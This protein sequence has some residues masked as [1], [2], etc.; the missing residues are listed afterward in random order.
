LRTPPGQHSEKLTGIGTTGA[1]G[2]V[3]GVSDGRAIL[4]ELQRAG[5]ADRDLAYD[6]VMA[7]LATGALPISVLRPSRG[8]ALV[9]SWFHRDQINKLARIAREPYLLEEAP[10]P[11]WV[12]WRR[13]ADDL[14]RTTGRI[15]DAS[16]R[17]EQFSDNGY[18]MCDFTLDGDVRGGFSFDDDERDPEESLASFV[19]TLCEGWLHEDVWG[20]WPLCPRHPDRPMWATLSDDGSA[21]WRCEVDPADQAA[22]GQLGT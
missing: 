9:S 6:A 18:W 21:V 20:G 1:V 12:P 5:V 2:N 4:A 14:Q 15:L 10:P 13:L 11:P 22:I 3:P 19:D 17:W 7:A 16:F 8:G